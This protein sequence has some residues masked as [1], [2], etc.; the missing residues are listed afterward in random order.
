M[1][2]ALL[3][4]ILHAVAISAFSLGGLLRPK[5]APR[6]SATVASDVQINI[7]KTGSSSDDAD[8]EAAKESS[9][10]AFTEQVKGMLDKLPTMLDEGIAPP[11]SAG[12]LQEALEANDMSE[13]FIL[14]YELNVD[15][16]CN[17]AMDNETKLMVTHEYEWNQDD[18]VCC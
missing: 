7:K 16:E 4:L 13:M 11:E 6:A 10:K 18:E 17:Y 1:R 9:I 2:L 5:A 8:M 14:F 15:I 3:L 12:K